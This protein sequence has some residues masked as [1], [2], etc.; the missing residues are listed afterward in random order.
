LRGLDRVAR[1]RQFADV[2]LGSAESAKENLFRDERHIDRIDAIDGNAAVDQG[3]GAIVI[4]DRD[5]EIELG[6]IAAAFLG[7]NIGILIA[8]R[9]GPCQDGR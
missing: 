4:A 8:A 2:E 9:R 7:A 5:G 6:H 1:Q 3:A